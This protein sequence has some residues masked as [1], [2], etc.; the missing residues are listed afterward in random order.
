MRSTNHSPVALVA[1]LLEAGADPNR[2]DDDGFPP[3]IAALSC[4]RAPAASTVRSDVH[5]LVEMLLAAGAD[6]GQRGINDYTPLHL[7]ASHG[8]LGALDILLAAGADPDAITRID[9]YEMALD[10]A[11]AAG[12]VCRGPA[13]PPDNRTTVTR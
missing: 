12:H 7:A 2:P 4:S 8:D 10:V 3:L 1:A 11:A 6:V 9:D 5:T 13:S